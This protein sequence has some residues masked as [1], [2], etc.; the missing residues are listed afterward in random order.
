MLTF[1]DND[2]LY[3][4]VAD[5]LREKRDRTVADWA[6]DYSRPSDLDALGAFIKEQTEQAAKIRM[7]HVEKVILG[8]VSN[9]L[10]AAADSGVTDFEAV[11]VMVSV[12]D[13]VA[14]ATVHVPTVAV[15]VSGIAPRKG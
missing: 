14:T 4:S 8:A 13:L 10:E 12:N 3:D 15:P 6:A 1:T 7:R 11:S 5:S 9:A 2:A